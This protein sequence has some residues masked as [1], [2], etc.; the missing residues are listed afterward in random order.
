MT[1]RFRVAALAAVV[2]GLMVTSY[3]A[4]RADAASTDAVAKLNQC[5][6]FL[7]KARALLD[8]TQSNR[9]GYGN[10]EKAK[11]SVDAA[12]LQV[13]KAVTANGG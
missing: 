12:M 5:H 4:G 10:V 3:F 8:A 11:A 6:D 9:M 2:S 7:T 13:E 1:A